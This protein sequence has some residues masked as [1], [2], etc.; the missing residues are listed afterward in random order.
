MLAVVV[1]AYSRPKETRRLIDSIVRARFDE[2]TVDLILSIDKSHCQQDVY[3]A[4]ADVVWK[5]GEYKMIMREQRMGLRPHILSCGE[6]TEHYDGVILLEDD[7]T[8]APDFY[9]YAK[10]ALDYY[11]DD[12]R[13]AQIALYSYAVNEFVSR[14]FY[15]A[16]NQYDVYAMQVTQ[17]WGQ[18]WS[19]R[20]WMAFK[21][22]QYYSCPT[23]APRDK[24]PANVN[25]W[26]ETSWKKNFTN[27]IADSD[28]YVIYP[29]CS[30]T[31]NHSV[32]GEHRNES[33]SSY[34]V[35]MQ[36]GEKEKFSFCTLEQCVKYDLFFERKGL[37]FETPA[38]QG[39]TVCIDLYGNKKYYEEAEMLFSTQ[40][41]QYKVVAECAL[42]LK[43]HENNLLRLE[44][45]RGIFL[46]DLSVQ[47]KKLPEKNLS[48]I[49]DFDLGCSYWRKTLKHGMRG[50]AKAVASRIKNRK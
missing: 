39:K 22:S 14:P 47:T 10:A 18:C 45:G 30:Y 46:Y 43:P 19:R 37:C 27:Y 38:C 34:H 44:E 28:K 26:K 6:M 7:L 21:E 49:I 9:R 40:R 25:R 31:T 42:S 33:V 23:I 29:Y 41:L 3:D 50:M 8:V 5:H 20:M 15:P 11:D 48:S 1:V 16:K 12:D 17:S 24:I 2:D 13:I 4:C 35:V 32:A 36:E